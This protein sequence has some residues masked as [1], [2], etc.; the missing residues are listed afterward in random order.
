MPFRDLT[1]KWDV[2]KRKRVCHKCGKDFK[3]N[4]KCIK[5]GPLMNLCTACMYSNI[6]A[7]TGGDDLSEL[8]KEAI[9]EAL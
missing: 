7:I 4:D 5:V 6:I 9:I 8:K 1:F 3:K 2:C